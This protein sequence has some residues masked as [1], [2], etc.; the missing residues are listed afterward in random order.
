MSRPTLIIVGAEKGGVGKTTVSRLVL[1]YLR[2]AGLEYRAFD[3]ETPKGTLKR[4]FPDAQVVDLEDSDGQVAVFD[5]IVPSR[6]TVLDLAARQ[7]SK[8]LKLLGEVGLLDA[9]R[10]GK[11]D[12]IVL[13]ILGSTVASFEEIKATAE[14]ITG[15]RY[16]I[17]TNHI[18]D[19]AY[20]GWEGEEA[21][22]ALGLAEAVINVPKLDTKSSEHVEQSAKSFADF[23]RE[24]PGFIFKGKVRHWL[25]G[26]L[27][28]LSVL[29]L[30]Q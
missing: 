22:K 29:K 21:Q 23:A 4:F 2:N 7:L 18:T 6:V 15:S 27:G 13:H 16:F 20:F 17:V 26:V 12:V 28:A 14:A 3:A 19:T 9:V 5:N 30:G 1:D 10:D 11:L 8:T 25:A 24:Y